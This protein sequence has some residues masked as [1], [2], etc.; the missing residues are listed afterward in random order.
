MFIQMMFNVCH[1]STN[2]DLPSYLDRAQSAIDEVKLFLTGDDYTKMVSNLDN[3]CMVFILHGL[4]RDFEYVWNQVLSNSSVPTAK[5][6]IVHYE[7]L[8]Q[9]P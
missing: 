8:I 2:Q 3:M 9:R 1:T 5:Q 6:L 4:H 7:S